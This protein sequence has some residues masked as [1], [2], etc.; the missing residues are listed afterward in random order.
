VRPGKKRDDQKNFDTKSSAA[1]KDRLG[2][3]KTERVNRMQGFHVNTKHFSIGFTLIE[4]LVVIAT[5]ALLL[6]ILIPSL[7]LGRRT[8]KA[9]VC[10][11]NLRRIGIGL[12]MY[13]RDNRDFYP[14]ALP[15]AP[16]ASPANS[17]DWLIPWPSEM[18]PISWQAGYPALTAPYLCDLQISNPHDY[19]SLRRQMGDSYIDLFRCPDNAIASTDLIARKCGF[20]LDYG[21]H[22][23]A[24]QNRNTD[25][26]IRRGFLAADQTWGL[27][28]VP[29]T[30]GPNEQL[31]LSGWWNP[32]VHPK[33]TINVL[34]PMFNVKRLSRE[35]FI[36]QFNTVNPPLDDP[37]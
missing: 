22:N 4:L 14:R 7:A 25:P 12:N 18:C 6:G 2:L 3:L 24:S 33:D 13:A 15:L 29:K 9:V 31:E 5:I 23:R 19:L 30:V 37:L 26:L 21:M 1:S 16:G 27:A 32:F 36:R 20:P 35:D 28:F 8:A 11:S 17:N 34:L 10:G